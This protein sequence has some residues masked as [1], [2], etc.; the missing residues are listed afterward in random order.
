MYFWI[1]SSNNPKHLKDT[2]LTLEFLKFFFD[3]ESLPICLL[4]VNTKK[5]TMYLFYKQ[6]AF[7]LKLAILCYDLVNIVFQY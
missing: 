6:Y 3:N 1:K 2:F 7:C 4:F 5:L